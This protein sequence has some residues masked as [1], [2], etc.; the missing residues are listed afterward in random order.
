[1]ETVKTSVIARG[2]EE[3]GMNRQRTEDFQ[4][5]ETILYGITID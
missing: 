4:G 2:W 3:N 5:S 1:M